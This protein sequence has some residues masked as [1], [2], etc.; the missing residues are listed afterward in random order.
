MIRSLKLNGMHNIRVTG[1]GKFAYDGD[2]MNIKEV[3]M[4][5]FEMD[6]YD[7]EAVEYIKGLQSIFKYSTMFIQIHAE[8]V[9]VE[10]IDRIKQLKDSCAIY[11][12]LDILDENILSNEV[13]LDDAIMD[14]L[15]Y[16]TDNLD[17]DGVS[18][19]D[20]S[21]ILNAVNAKALIDSAADEFGWDKKTIS[22]C[23]SPLSCTGYACITAVKAREIMAKYSTEDDVPLPTANHEK[24]CCGCIQ[25]TKIEH[26]T[27][28]M[29]QKSV[30]SSNSSTGSKEKKSVKKAGIRFGATRF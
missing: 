21:T 20:K 1:D 23:N 17:L 14:S 3:P 30:K 25:F 29:T 28:V 9:S 19:V 18:L 24:S 12:Y 11:L 7:D 5:R 2:K 4:I 8:T 15:D 26:D 27:D 22:I 10:E 16:A 13:A 6:K